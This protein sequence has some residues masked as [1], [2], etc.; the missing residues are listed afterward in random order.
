MMLCVDDLTRFKFISFLKHKSDAAK[1]LGELVAEHIASAGI[2]IGTVRTDGGGDSK[3]EFLSLLKELEIKRETPSTGADHAPQ[4]TSVPGMA[5]LAAG[6]H[7]V[8]SPD[9][10]YA[11]KRI[12]ST[13][14]YSQGSRFSV[15]T[16]DVALG[17]LGLVQSTRL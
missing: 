7:P 16:V 12:A 17:V 5:K 15:G 11:P 9:R 6:S 8:S 3:G 2:K 1:E 10:N 13:T 4:S 14:P